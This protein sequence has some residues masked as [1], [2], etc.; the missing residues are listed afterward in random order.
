MAAPRVE[1]VGWG[2]LAAGWIAE[3]FARAMA[4]SATGRPAAVASR[5]PERAADFAARH[6][7][8]DVHGS[9]EE[10][11]VNPEV[12]VVYVST[13]HPMHAEW[14]IAAMDAGK[15]VLCEKPIAMDHAEAVSMVA[16]AKR[17]DV[18]LMEAF[19]YR[20]HPQT[21]ALI[22]AIRAGEIGRPRLI[23][24]S[25][26]FGVETH[27][28]P[29]LFENALG[30]GSILDVGCYPLS[31]ARMIAAAAADGDGAHLLDLTASAHID[32]GQNVDHFAAATLRFEGDVHA[33]ISCG[34]VLG[35]EHS[36]K[37]FGTEGDLEVVRPSWSDYPPED[38]EIRI[39][40]AGKPTKVVR[41]SAS[42]PLLTYQIDH[43]AEHL[44]QRQSPCMSWADSLENMR[45]L[46][47]WR[48]AVGLTY[49]Q[50]RQIAGRPP[51]P[52]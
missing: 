39:R 50:P 3:R 25:E 17:N 33:Y 45:A 9:Y 1:Q 12:D 4:E 21:P 19:A 15:H 37:V 36:L 51:P 11:L 42:K 16:A 48:E 31:A 10:L 32:A 30:G 49:D 52:A 28:L 18:F 5:S 27:T 7:V 46:D 8:P 2:F 24:S 40:R 14:S 23:T 47:R 43:V 44:G 34:M 35:E 6:Q 41:V 29:R 38:S 22:D 13:P 20:T 26:Y